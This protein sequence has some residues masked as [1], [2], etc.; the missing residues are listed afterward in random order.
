MFR[1]DGAAEI[2][3]FLNPDYWGGQMA[4][5][6][7]MRT[8]PLLERQT[9]V[10]SQ[11]SGHDDLLAPV[12]VMANDRSGLKTDAIYIND[13]DFSPDNHEPGSVVFYRKEVLVNDAEKA[14]RLTGQPEE[15]PLAP[16][17]VV[18]KGPFTPEGGY[19]TRLVSP[20]F[21]YYSG[22]RVGRVIKTEDSQSNHMVYL[23]LMGYISRQEKPGKGVA[24]LIGNIEPT[25]L[26][27][28]VARR[29]ATRSG[30]DL[31]IRVNALYVCR[32]APLL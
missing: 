3:P 1:A 17:L 7:T 11:L 16:G 13:E 4:G 27:I 25:P 26:T 9:V 31:L 32:K 2:E 12:T 14:T 24:M 30:A 21:I 15:K 29:Y 6:P 20:P 28:G 8:L 18:G 22:D 23:S 19:N 5:R 10:A